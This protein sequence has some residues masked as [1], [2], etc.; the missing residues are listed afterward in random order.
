M[1]FL[2]SLFVLTVPLAAHDVQIPSIKVNQASLDPT[3]PV[4]QKA[5]S[6][7][8]LLAPQKLVV[9][10]GG[11]DVSYVE[12]RSLHT[13]TH[14][15]LFLRW[16]D[17]AQNSRVDLSGRFAD[18]CAV[19]F[20][21]NT[22]TMPSP[23]MGERGSPVNIWRWSAAMEES[24]R[25]PKAYAD[26][27]RPDAIEKTYSFYSQ[28]ED[29]VAEGFGTLERHKHQGVEAKGRWNKG[30]WTVVFHRA[31]KTQEG[32]TLSNGNAVP[33]AFAIWNGSK[34][35][36]NG[37]KSFSVWQTLLIG[38]SSRQVEKNVIE[39]GRRIYGRYGCA[40]CH[41]PNGKG[42]VSNPGA[43]IDPIPALERVAEG[44]TEEEVKAVIRNGRMPL[45]K[46]PQAPTPRLWMNSWKTLM[47]EEELDALVDY[48]FSLMPKGGEEW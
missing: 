35:D 4:W 46:D 1:T 40:T 17:S 16:K 11:G 25:Y 7:E 2:F 29:L 19:E 13:E 15:F 26:Y 42:G 9:P 44:F 10:Q 3:D 8:V 6:V 28:A 12:V 22:E 24:N 41:G 31:L 34:G 38:T 30:Y 21:L 5:T 45:A 36:R 33:I 14:L 20:P 43:Q 39:R 23:F 18:A 47:N 32:A 48:L 27:H 37:S